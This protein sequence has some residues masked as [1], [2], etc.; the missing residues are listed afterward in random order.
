MLRGSTPAIIAENIRLLKSRGHSDESAT[1]HA[2]EHS[3]FHAASGGLTSAQRDALPD[4]AFALPGRRY[5]IHNESHARNALSRVAQHGT[6][7]EKTSVRR[8][9]KAR[10]PHIK[11]SNA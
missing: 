6:P 7:E 2:H 10:F 5:P 1:K 8:A 4:E 9:V 3:K 11:V